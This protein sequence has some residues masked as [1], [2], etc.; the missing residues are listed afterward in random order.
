MGI[1]RLGPP[2]DTVLF[3]QQTKNIENFVE[4]GTYYGCTAFWASNHFTRVYTI[5]L[6]KKLFNQVKSNNSD[7]NNIEFIL[8][9]S[10]NELKM[11]CKKLNGS[12]IFWL[13]AHFTTPDTSGVGEDAPI[14]DEIRIINKHSGAKDAFI[15][16]DDARLFLSPPPRPHPIE[17]FVDYSLILSE[18][19]N[20]FDREVIVFEDVIIAVPGEIRE[21]FRMHIQN[22]VTIAW[23]NHSQEINRSDLQ[24]SYFYFLKWIKNK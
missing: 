20:S 23:E 5:E 6:S 21:K 16:I 19:K 15:L 24:K 2:E 13:D 10:R 9:D 8:G 4:T 3:L 18:L 14:I 7:F 17:S 12:A 22:A 1:F 11:V